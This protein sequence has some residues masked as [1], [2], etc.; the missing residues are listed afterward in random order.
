MVNNNY[1]IGGGGSGAAGS[2]GVMDGYGGNGT[3]NHNN[4]IQWQGKV[5]RK[6]KKNENIR[7]I[8]TLST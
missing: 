2:G 5:K 8:M 6:E 7:L 3:V 4:M 1:V